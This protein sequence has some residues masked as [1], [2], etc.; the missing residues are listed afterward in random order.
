VSSP[1]S[2]KNRWFAEEVQSHEP[3]L[4]AYLR[5]KFPSLPDLDD[6][7]QETYARLWRASDIGTVRSA[8]AFLFTT[9]RNVAFDLFRRRNVVS[10]EAMSDMNGLHVLD[11][12]PGVADTVCHEQELGLM[13]D[14]V[15]A[16][17]D[18]CREVLTLRKIYDLSHKEIAA[19][20]DISESTVNAQIAIGLLRC[21]EYL[22]A[23]GVT[24]AHNHE[25]GRQQHEA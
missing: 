1:S 23:R 10:I 7:V 20:L 8:K 3:A 4:R 9:A 14:A 2:E 6:L 11:D 24:S 22:R 16:L 21:R 15:R 12:R 18:R 5:G 17:P 19:R 25:R 13:L